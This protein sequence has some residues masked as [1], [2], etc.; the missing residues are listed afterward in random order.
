MQRFPYDLKK[1]RWILLFIGV[2]ILLFA[3][4]LGDAENWQDIVYSFIPASLV[5]TSFLHF[6]IIH[7][8]SNMYCI[9]I[10][11]GVLCSCM[12]ARKAN[13]WTLPLLFLI[14]SVVTG[15]LPY[16]LQP[17]AYTAGASGTVYALEAYVFVIAF[18]GR[19]DPLAIALRRQS[20]WLII[21]AII[22][23]I[24]F[25]NTEVSFVGHFSGAIVGAIVALFDLH[26][27]RQ[28]KKFNDNTR[29]QSDYER[30]V[31]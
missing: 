13:G 31:R 26:R 25:F 12:S 29:Q 9:F 19:D 8:L 24:W 7:L 6:G 23:V 22:A 21:N 18:A 28:I 27:R 14:A 2:N 16:Y 15:I 11:G 4:S 30:L 20:R 5:L 3:L 17:E 10:F 1:M